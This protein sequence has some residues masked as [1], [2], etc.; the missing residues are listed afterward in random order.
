MPCWHDVIVILMIKCC[1]SKINKLYSTRFWKILENRTILDWAYRNLYGEKKRSL[2]KKWWTEVYIQGNLK[3]RTDPN[4]EVQ[5]H[6][7]IM[8]PD[9]IRWNK[10]NVLWLQIRVNKSQVM[11]NC[12]GNKYKLFLCICTKEEKWI[13]PL[14]LAY[15]AKERTKAH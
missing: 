8:N 6:L 12:I 1:A 4:I 3:F 13:G 15:T 10:K 11:H 7:I 2:E 9:S 14:E 5:Y